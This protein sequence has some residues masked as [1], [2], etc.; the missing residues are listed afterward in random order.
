METV[1]ELLTEV[2]DLLMLICTHGPIVSHLFVNFL[3][4]HQTLF[5][6]PLKQHIVWQFLLTHQKLILLGTK[7]HLVRAKFWAVLKERFRVG[8]M[9]RWVEWHQ[10][11][12]AVLSE[13]TGTYQAY[14][15]YRLLS[16][17]WACLRQ[18]RLL[19]HQIIVFRRAILVLGFYMSCWK[20]WFLSLLYFYPI[21]DRFNLF[22][23]SQ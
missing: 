17:F 16:V 6:L 13:K 18:N 12:Q 20:Y 14:I 19:F 7:I 1:M 10:W 23:Q 3:I 8:V 2:I 11:V 15:R 9:W 21:H 5:L 4:F 22:Y